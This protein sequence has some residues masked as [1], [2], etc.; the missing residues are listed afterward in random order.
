ME[1]VILLSGIVIGAVA[2]WL[3]AKYK[4]SADNASL[5]IEQEKA[6]A[7]ASQTLDLKKELDQLRQTNLEMN[8]SLSSAEADYRNLQEK[9]TDQKKE[10]ETLQERFTVQFENLAN[11]IF[12]EKSKKFTEQNKT[13]LTD[14]LKPLGEK[15]TEF[16]KRIDLSHK[17]S[18]AKNASL[19]NE[20]KN[21]KELNL[22]MG[23]DARN[24]TRALKSDT[25]TQGSWGE[26]ILETILEK[27]GLEKVGNTQC[28]K[29]FIPKNQD[30]LSL[31]Q[32]WV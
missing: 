2:G 3:I 9:L 17:D 10:L 7:L 24:L 22:Q 1:I 14:V 8:T 16:E 26:L 15:I 27:S 32:K 25:K 30:I 20:L 4:F 12:E 11:K 31:T 13:N 5:A 28:R 21:L 18:I 6:R 29:R 19:F 23:E